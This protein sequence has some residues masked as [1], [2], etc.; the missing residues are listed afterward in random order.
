MYAVHYVSEHPYKVFA[1]A[2][3]QIQVHGLK[4]FLKPELTKAL[5]ALFAEDGRS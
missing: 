4:E 3:R 1:P 2:G 5:L